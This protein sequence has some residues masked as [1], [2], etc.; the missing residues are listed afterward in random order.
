MKYGKIYTYENREEASKLVGKKVVGTDYFSE[1]VSFGKELNR[2]PIIYTLRE[3]IEGNFPFSVL[4][5]SVENRVGDE[6]QF[7]REIIE[8]D[9]D[10]ALMTNRQLAEWLGRGFGQYKYNN[11]HNSGYS[12]FLEDETKEVIEDVLVRS[13][14]SDEWI[15]PTKKI[16]ERDCMGE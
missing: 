5:E 4:R 2:I 8:E 14:G 12:Y 13:W 11:I 9:E 16:Y 7:M 1:V 3:V 15:K 6:F 10:E